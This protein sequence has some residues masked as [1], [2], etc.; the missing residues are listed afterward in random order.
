MFSGNSDAK[1]HAPKFMWD[2]K[3]VGFK[4]IRG[5]S[6]ARK[7]DLFLVREQNA[8]PFDPNADWKEGDMVPD[9]VI[10][11]A[12]ASGSAADNNAIA[13]W[14]DGMWTVVMVRPLGLTNADDKLLKAGGVYNIGFAVH[15]DNITTR[16][17]HVS[18][19]K[20]LG[21]GAKA[22]IKATKLR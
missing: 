6:Q 19:V 22:D 16:G 11:R 8:V 15:D 4:S 12:D 18:F 21:F 2:E 1:T 17:H 20:T 9:Y 10:S 7:G 3:K 13:S 5:D 14:K